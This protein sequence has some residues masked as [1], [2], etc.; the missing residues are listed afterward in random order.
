MTSKAGGKRIPGW[1][2]REKKKQQMGNP[3]G[4]GVHRTGRGVVGAWRGKSKQGAG[5]CTEVM[6]EFPEL[7]EDIKP[8]MREG[9]RIPNRT[10]TR[11][12]ASSH[13]EQN[14]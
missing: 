11:K 6:S 13:I 9:L 4:R 10:H 3:G 5:I 2:S 12:T 8:C 7:T 1:K 14:C